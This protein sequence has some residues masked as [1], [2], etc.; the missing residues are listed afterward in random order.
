MIAGQPEKQVKNPKRIKAVL[1]ICTAET[2][3]NIGSY[4]GR[5]NPSPYR[6]SEKEPAANA[7]D[8]LFFDI[9][10]CYADIRI[11]P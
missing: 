5:V 6:S 9:Q 10:I 8:S 3:Q 1:E 11:T 4:E 2:Q 7:A